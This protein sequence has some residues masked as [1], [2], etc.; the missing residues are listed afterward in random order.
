M[1]LEGARIV[2]VGGAGLVGSYIVERL[3]R[4]PVAEV[5]VF[6]NF[7]RGTRGN[8][9]G[10]DGHGKLRIVEGSMTDRAALARELKDADGVFLLASLWLGECVSDPRSAWEI[11]TLGS[12]NVVEACLDAGV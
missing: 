6:D 2:L 7:V 8:L 4:E 5:V 10:V 1:K 3:L 12:W 11:N 9:S